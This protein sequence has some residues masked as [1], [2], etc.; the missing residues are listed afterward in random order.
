MNFPNVQLKNPKPTNPRKKTKQNPQNNN[1]KT[2]PKT[3][4]QP[5]KPNTKPNIQIKEKVLYLEI[6]HQPIVTPCLRLTG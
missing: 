4:N 1:Q 2:T 6:V 5:K 3:S